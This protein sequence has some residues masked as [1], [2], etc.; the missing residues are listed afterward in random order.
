MFT[1]WHNH[2]VFRCVVV[3]VFVQMVDMLI[4]LKR[5][6]DHDLRDNSVLMATVQLAIGRWL[7]GRETLDLRVAVIDATN[8][9]GR[10]VIGITPST[11]ALCVHSAIAV[12]TL[13]DGL[14][15]SLVTADLGWPSRVAPQKR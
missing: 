9:F 15:T 6:T 3:F 7:Y 8:V 4:G 5:T 12:A 11:Q 1:G 14:A 13:F 2:E 10:Y